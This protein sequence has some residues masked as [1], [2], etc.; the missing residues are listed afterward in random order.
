MNE[1]ESLLSRIASTLIGD[2]KRAKHQ[3]TKD[4]RA[5]HF[6]AFHPYM[7]VNQV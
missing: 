7:V 2:D 5:L 6:G 4:A 3:A 1:I